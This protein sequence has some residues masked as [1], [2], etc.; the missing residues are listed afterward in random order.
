MGVLK[1]LLHRL[2]ELV[3]IVAILVLIPNLPP[4]AQFS[5]PISVKPAKPF[6]GPLS[7]N[8]KLDD[9]EFWHKGDFVGPEAFADFN[10][11]LY[12]SLYTGDIVK[13][14]GDHITPI[15]KFGKPCKD[16]LDESI[17]GRPLGLEFSKDGLLYAADAYYGIFKV[18]VNTG[19]KEQ[20]VSPKTE[21]EGKFPKLFNSLTLTSNGDIYWTDSTSEFTLE[22]GIFSILA[23]P[24][25]RL[26]HYD[27]KTKRN[28]VL[29]D[30]I[31]FANGVALSKDE[32]FIIVAE[33][34]GSRLLRYYLKGPKKG[35]HDVFIDGLPGL[36]DNLKGDGKGGF[37]VPLVLG[38]DAD[39]PAILQSILPL[40]W[41][42]KTIARILG[43]AE[44]IFK[45]IDQYYPNDFS[46]R[47]V[48]HIGHFTSI[49][50]YLSSPRVTILRLNY[51]GEITNSAH[52]VNKKL[53]AISEMHVFR[54]MLYLGSP[55]NDYIARIPLAKL[56]WEDLKKVEERVK[57]EASD[58]TS[59]P[60][61]TTRASNPTTAPPT[62]TTTIPK[63]TTST[64]KP[65]TA[66]PKLSTTTLKPTTTTP[67]PTTTTPK[68]TTTTP[69]STTATPK[70][71]TVPSSPPTTTTPKS[72]TTTPK[73][74]TTTVPPP[75]PTTTS[76]SQTPPPK[77]KIS[78]PEPEKRQSK[79]APPPQ[80]TAT[81][82]IKQAIPSVTQAPPEQAQQQRQAPTPAKPGHRKQN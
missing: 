27:S 24:S 3:L 55:W 67:K 61:T 59:K 48:H 42:R 23:D 4:K 17:C 16:S 18:D 63:P 54:D 21:I 53:H 56:G 78:S 50:A 75:P 9:V 69:K 15:V 35:T 1:F 13:L 25:G 41:L 29:L 52:T 77:S 14:T 19:K 34:M 6:T 60:T 73:P 39:Y 28:H 38:R 70:F 22:D 43:V 82:P 47:V 58:T 5:K 36:P 74:T 32:E 10:G 2:F 8:Q 81:P 71:K 46:L 20:L 76:K 64:P 31:H 65:T 33:T 44:Y 68:P 45:K 72:T 12:T 79:Q 40:P 51:N 26:M 80:P 57:R 7:L 66:T 62:S 11:E 30:G 37:F 49:P